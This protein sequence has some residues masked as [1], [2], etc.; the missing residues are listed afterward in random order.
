MLSSDQ[1]NQNDLLLP[2]FKTFIESLC[3]SNRNEG[4]HGQISFGS[5]FEQRG[6]C[7]AHSSL[8][9][10]KPRSRV[11]FSDGYITRNSVADPRNF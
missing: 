5:I 10:P 8:A 7:I 4:I 2:S 6:L 11:C 1:F 9:N 3:G